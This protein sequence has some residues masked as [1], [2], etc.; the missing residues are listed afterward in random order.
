MWAEE[1]GVQGF[2][3]VAAVERPRRF[4]WLGAWVVRRAPLGL[5]GSPVSQGALRHG[6]TCRRALE[7]NGSSEFVAFGIQI[8]SLRALE[9]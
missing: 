4:G 9:L 6:C 8:L 5:L 2:A 3:Q 7:S 1:F